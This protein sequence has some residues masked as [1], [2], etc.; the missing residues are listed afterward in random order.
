VSGPLGVALTGHRLRLPAILRLARR[1]DELGYD[2][3]LVD[4]DAAVV[5]SRPD[6]PIYEGLTLSG[7]VL[8]CTA[9]ARAGSIRLPLFWNPVLLAR[10]LATLQQGSG[11]RALGFFGVGARRGLERAGLGDT[12][13]AERLA[14]LEE[15]LDALRPLLR[16][17]TVT[18]RG[19]HVRMESISL[20]VLER[21]LP[22]VVSAARP[23][24]LDLVDR[25]ADVWDA[26]VPPHPERVEPLRERLRRPV[27]TWIWAFARPGASLEAAASAYRQH[28]PWF[29]DLPE[30]DVERALLYGE[31]AHC[32]ERLDSLRLELGVARPILDLIG[33][34]EE[35]AAEALDALAPAKDPPI[36]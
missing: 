20:P 34:Q 30:R 28:C 10:A 35:E 24:A 14:W 3:V 1:A 25:Y 9:R 13:A 17:E 8:A 7:W 4:G 33:L 16:G 27:E 22:L 31:R 2:V 6:A 36:S 5:P 26:N 18:R 29:V 12:P 21:P 32:R 11:G 15:M 23:R 19:R